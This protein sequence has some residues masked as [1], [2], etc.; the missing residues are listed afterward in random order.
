M[1]SA[2]VLNRE[3]QHAFAILEA[4]SHNFCQRFSGANARGELH[5]NVSLNPAVDCTFI[6]DTPIRIE[7]A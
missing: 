3:G 6:I 5:A 4:A 2:I 7:I 1:C